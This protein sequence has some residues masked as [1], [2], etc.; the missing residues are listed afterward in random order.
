[1]YIF[2]KEMSCCIFFIGIQQNTI[3]ITLLFMVLDLLY[4]YATIV[5]IQT[6]HSSSKTIG[7]SV[8]SEIENSLFWT[9]TF[10]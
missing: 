8:V 6:L 3:F 2:Y 7:E 4:L 9:A 1:M 5:N 10:Y